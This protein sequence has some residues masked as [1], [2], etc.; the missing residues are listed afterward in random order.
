[1]RAVAYMRVSK[2]EEELENQRMKINE[3]AQ[4]NGFSDVLFFSDEDVSG[5][6]PC[7]DRKGFQEMLNFLRN[8]TEIK[9]II[10]LDMTRLGRNMEDNLNVI[11]KLREDGYKLHFINQ[12]FLSMINDPSFEK[13]LLA[14]FSWFAE[15]ER[16]MIIYRT[17]LGLQRAKA[18]G[19]RLGR[20]PKLTAEQIKTL[21]ELYQKGVSKSSIAKILG[22]NRNTVYHYLQ[23]M[24]LLDKKVEGGVVDGRL[25]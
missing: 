10:F 9:D 3:Y 11:K 16:E 1:M 25:S 20:P 13:L 8:N 12:P 19:K 14:I 7:F 21:R 18:Q 2:E 24:G 6:V 22:V 17:R 23:K 4:K 15:Y 5:A